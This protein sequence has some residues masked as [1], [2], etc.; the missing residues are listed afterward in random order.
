LILKVLM[1]STARRCI[2]MA[3]LHALIGLGIAGNF[4]HHLEQAGEAEDFIE[5]ETTSAEAPKG[6]FP[7]YLPNTQGDRLSLFPLSSTTIQS[8]GENLQVEP[9]VGLLCDLDYDED[10]R[11]VGLTPRA[12]TAYNDCSIR[13]KAPKISYKKHWGACSKGVSEEWIEIDH[14]TEKGVMQ[15]Y[16]IAS[17]LKRDG[18]LHLYGNTSKISTYN[19]IYDQLLVWCIEKLN[20]QQDQGPLEN[21]SDCLAKSHYPKQAL[22]S[23]GATSYTE[24]GESTYL[25]KGDEVFVIL[26]DHTRYDETEV[27]ATLHKNGTLVAASTLH[28]TVL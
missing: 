23:I 12:F 5:I 10:H 25:Q 20:T 2:K 6:I 24:F 1:K 22:M 17:F 11:V 19:Y 27:K 18:V 21:L 16:S 28:Q 14:F 13:K 15:R 8:N 7:F 9:E 3:D 26:F 4:A